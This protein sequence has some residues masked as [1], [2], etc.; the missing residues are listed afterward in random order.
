MTKLLLRRS[1]PGEA[2]AARLNL[3][4]GSRASIFIRSDLR[5]H[6]PH[7]VGKNNKYEFQAIA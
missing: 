3:P 7:C 2:A 5:T 1:M 6:A 4:H